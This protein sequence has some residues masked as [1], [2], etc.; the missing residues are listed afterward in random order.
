MSGLFIE[1]YTE[2]H[3]RADIQAA[4]GGEVW[5]EGALIHWLPE[6]HSV[7]VQ[8]PDPGHYEKFDAIAWAERTRTQWEQR[9]VRL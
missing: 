6:N 1:V 8:I 2:Q 4:L 7:T 9:G 5:W 3:R